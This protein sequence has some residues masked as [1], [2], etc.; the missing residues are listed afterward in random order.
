M[1]ATMIVAVIMTLTPADLP[2]IEAVQAERYRRDFRAFVG[3]AWPVIE[4][5]PL[6]SSWHIDALC[7]AL[8]AVAEKKLFKILINIP[9]R[10]AKTRIVSELFPCWLWARDPGVR[11][12]VASYS[13]DLSRESNRVRRLLITSD[14]YGARWGAA[15]RGTTEL[16]DDANKVT[17]FRNRVGGAMIA[18]SVGATVTGRGGDILILDDPHNVQHGESDAERMSTQWWFDKVWATRKNDLATSPEI[19]IMQRVHT[20]DI[21][22]HILRDLDPHHASWVHLKLPMEYDPARRCVIS[23]PGFTFADPRTEAGEILHPARFPRKELDELK[24]RMHEYATAGQLQQ[25]PVPLGGAMFK[26][27]WVRYYSQ[28]DPEGWHS[29]EPIAGSEYKFRPR[30][31]FVFCTVDPAVSDKELVGGATRKKLL[32]PDS[33]AIGVWAANWTPRGPWVALLDVV[34]ERLTAPDILTALHS[35]RAR[36]SPSVMFLE[37]IGFQLALFQMARKEG[38]PVREVSTRDD[39]EVMYR[40]TKDKVG[41]AM[42]AHPLMADGR[43]FVPAWAPQWLD[44]YLAQLLTFP[45]SAH[46]DMVDM[47][48]MAVNII[49]Q[50]PQGRLLE[51]GGEDRELGAR[52]RAPAEAGADERVR[53]EMWSSLR[54]HNNDSDNNG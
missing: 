9:P 35:V 45:S 27:A 21:S 28:P 30:D 33:T 14:W 10:T 25:E 51:A 19:V 23:V 4:P 7:A 20:D 18:T 36:W 13:L 40:I 29:L 37:S 46:D 15:G 31:S 54:G 17:E 44:P 49:Q 47:T 41:R 53:E 8:Q 11:A 26:R 50:I 16:A 48:T 12:L 6:K 1:I 2:T 34:N 3:A 5:S 39:P 24:S 43:F 38:L 52:K 32:D 22:G 42:D